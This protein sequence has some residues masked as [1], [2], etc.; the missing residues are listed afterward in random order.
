[1]PEET[2]QGPSLHQDNASLNHA[3]VNMGWQFFLY[4]FFLYIFLL[5]TFLLYTDAPRLAAAAA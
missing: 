4:I 2:T 1:M 5:H 3:S